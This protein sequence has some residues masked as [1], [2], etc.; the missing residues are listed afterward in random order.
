MRAAV[1]SLS[2]LTVLAACAP[3]G[4]NAAD[5]GVTR[6]ERQCFDVRQVDNF[7]SG[8]TG[9]LYLRVRTREVYSVQTGVC[10]D[11][12]YAL[13]LAILPEGAAGLSSQLCT[14]D[15]ARLVTPGTGLPNAPCRV[16]IERRLSAEEIA[17]LPSRYR[18]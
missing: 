11:V 1:L 9:T 3:T 13:Q 7:R 5:A 16:R 6:R 4:Q 14:G 8:D 12:D 15:W 18:P 17:A 2:L 10:N